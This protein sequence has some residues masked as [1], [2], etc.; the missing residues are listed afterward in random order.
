M[1][2]LDGLHAAL[3]SWRPATDLNQHFTVGLPRMLV[4]SR[5]RIGG[6][7]VSL[8]DRYHRCCI[9]PTLPYDLYLIYLC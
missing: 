3:G 5:M 2:L 7:I 9:F 1:G 4:K 8:R 6:E